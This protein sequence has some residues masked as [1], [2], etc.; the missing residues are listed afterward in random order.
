MIDRD[1]TTL[2]GVDPRS[3]ETVFTF[4]CAEGNLN[5]V[6][7]MIAHL[8]LLYPKMVLVPENKSSGTGFID[9]VA[10]LLTQRQHNPWYRIFNWVVNNR[11][12]EEF[13][14]VDLRDPS[15]IHTSMKKYFGIKTDKSKRDELYSS[16]LMEGASKAASKIRDQTLIQELAS[17]TVRNGRV[18]HASGGHDDTVVGWLLSIW[19]ILSGKH[20][21]MYG[22]KPGTV[23]SYTDASK[24]DKNKLAEEHQI[25]LAQRIKGLEDLLRHQHDPSLKRLLQSDIALCK[26]M[27]DPKA[28][29]IPETTDE[30]IRDPKRYTDP[31]TAEKSR[32]QVNIDDVERSLRM[33]LNVS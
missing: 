9:T 26:S 2:V 22:I 7:A 33:F 19:V 21:D 29:P 12:E 4:R 14:K 16:T 32:P 17:L 31:I 25:K 15:L 30:L 20:L 28:V 6:G 18:D 1:A 5:K 23:L 11:H 24:P 13:A 3:L 10:L 27:I 8:M